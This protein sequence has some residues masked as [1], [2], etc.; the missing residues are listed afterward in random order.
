MFNNSSTSTQLFIVL[1]G[2]RQELDTANTDWLQDNAYHNIEVIRSGSNIA[3]KFDGTQILSATDATH[4]LGQLG[5]GSYNDSAYFDN[6]AVLGV[7][8]PI[9]VQTKNDTTSN[10][11]TNTGDSSTSGTTGG[12]T[13]SAGT[14][15]DNGTSGSLSK[16]GALS[17]LEIMSLLLAI[18]MTLLRRKQLRL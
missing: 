18:G 6:I 13:G 10:D 7:A 9:T 5:V 12:T 11:T 16:T 1:D 2:V 14:T 17:A 3:V 4:G 15:D 8:T